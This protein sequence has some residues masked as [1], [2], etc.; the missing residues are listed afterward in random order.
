VNSDAG[1]Y[2]QVDGTLWRV[3]DA[4]LDAFA[5][6]DDSRIMAEINAAKY[7]KAPPPAP[8]R[9]QRRAAAREKRRR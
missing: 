9:A 2:V 3:S 1:G 8:N 7:V 5:N 6:G 4:A